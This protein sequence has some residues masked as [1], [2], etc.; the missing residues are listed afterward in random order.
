MVEA[1]GFGVDP[2]DAEAA[3]VGVAVPDATGEG[4]GLAPV[5]LVIVTCVG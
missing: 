2:G 4:D 1:D 3:G 5:A